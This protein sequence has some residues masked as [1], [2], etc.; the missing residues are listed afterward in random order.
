MAARGTFCSFL[1]LEEVS[2]PYSLPG[3]T[4]QD[5]YSLLHVV[6]LVSL[7]S[8]NSS[9]SF[10]ESFNLILLLSLPFQ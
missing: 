3:F 4:L 5:R 7:P 10:G 1:Y 2:V 6:T 9:K 8:M